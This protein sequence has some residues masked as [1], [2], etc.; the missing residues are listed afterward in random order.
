MAKWPESR[1]RFE[2]ARLDKITG[3]NGQSLEIKIG[4]GKCTLGQFES[5]GGEPL[6]FRFSAFFF[7]NDDFSYAAA[8]DT[9]RHEYAHYMDLVL[10]GHHSHGYTWRRCCIRIGARPERFYRKEWNEKKRSQEKRIIE[11]WKY[12]PK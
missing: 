3:L 4:K 10:Y 11:N 6:R 12:K 1:I 7:E 5:A 9:I 2:I 8:I